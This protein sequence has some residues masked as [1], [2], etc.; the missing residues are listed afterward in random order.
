VPISV[1]DIFIT[2]ANSIIIPARLVFL[3]PFYNF[4]VI[5]YDASLIGDTPVRP[6]EFS[7]K[8]LMQ[9]DETFQIGIGTDHSVVMKKTTISSVTNIGTK[10]CSPPR[11]RAMNV[12][13]IKIDDSANSQGAVLTDEEG[14]TQALWVNYSSQNEKGKD[15]S[16]MCG[17][18]I[19]LVRPVIEPLIRGEKHCS[20]KNPRIK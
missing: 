2:F 14:K 19:D 9:G 16:F 10:E 1:G 15:I 17:L 4:V 6:L 20:G 13:G 5:T 8:T 11:W 18:P 12:E 3:H 7:H